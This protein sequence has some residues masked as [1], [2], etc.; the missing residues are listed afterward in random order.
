MDNFVPA[1]PPP[2]PMPTAADPLGER[3][4]AAWAP[5]QT[6]SLAMRPAATVALEALENRVVE[7]EQ[8]IVELLSRV[9]PVLTPLAPVGPQQ[10]MPPVPTPAPRS[11]LC[12]SVD[13]I[14]LSVAQITKTVNDAIKRVEV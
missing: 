14:A 3:A 1:P 4:K 5:A 13:S 11:A 7:L 12:G 9:Q 8:S 6:V 10:P 2:L